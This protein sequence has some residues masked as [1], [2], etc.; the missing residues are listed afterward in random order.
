MFAAATLS[1]TQL[2][3]KKYADFEARIQ[4]EFH[5]ALQAKKVEL[6]LAD[7]P[8]SDVETPVSGSVEQ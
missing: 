4:T 2:A 6:G 7:A 8:P 3:A 1:P 5:A